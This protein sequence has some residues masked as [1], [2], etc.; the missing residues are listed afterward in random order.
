MQTKYIP[1]QKREQVFHPRVI[2]ITG[3]LNPYLHISRIKI[4][5]NFPD[6]Y[7]EV[8]CGTHRDRITSRQNTSTG[9]VSKWMKMKIK[10][11]PAV[12]LACLIVFFQ[13][14]QAQTHDTLF[15]ENFGTT[16]YWQGPASDYMGYSSSGGFS[17]NPILILNYLPSNY[18]GA[19]G[20]S[21]LILGVNPAEDTLMIS[22]IDT[23]YY[24]SLDLS[25]GV[26]AQVDPAADFRIAFSTDGINWTGFDNSKLLAGSWA[27]K[28]S[29]L[30]G[31]VTYTDSLPESSNLY[32]M[33]RNTNPGKYLYLDDIRINGVYDS[34]SVDFL[35]SLSADVGVMTPLFNS[36]ITQYNI[37]L[38][39]GTATAPVITAIAPTSQAVVKITG[40][41][42]VTSADES[43]RTATI[44]VQSGDGTSVREYTMV[45]RVD[46]KL[47]IYFEDFDVPGPDQ[48]VGPADKYS[49]RTSGLTTFLA[50]DSVK[51]DPFGSKFTSGS[52]YR[53]LYVSP[54]DHP[55][56][57]TITFANIDVT[58]SKEKELSFAFRWSTG[59]VDIDHYFPTVEV[60]VD[61]G[62]WINYGAKAGAAA[63]PGPQTWALVRIP[64]LPEGDTMSIRFSS[65][66]YSGSSQEYFIDDF[67]IL[68]KALCSDTTL[69]S[70]KID[71]CLLVPAFD[72]SVPVYHVDLEPGTTTVPVAEALEN[73]SCATVDIINASNPGAADSATRT[74]VIIIHAEDG[75]IGEYK[76]VFDYRP[77]RTEAHLAFLESDMGSLDPVFSP[78]SLDY[79]IDLPPGTSHTPGIKAISA[80]TVATL[81]ITS[82]TD[83]MSANE[84][85][86]TTTIQVLAEDTLTTITY[87]ILFNSRPLSS[88][89]HLTSLT[90]DAGILSPDFTSD[91]LGYL[92]ELLPGETVA[93]VIAAVPEDT[94]A[95]VF[96]QKAADILSSGDLDR[97]SIITVVAEDKVTT[98]TYMILFNVSTE[99]TAQIRQNNF[100]IWPNPSGDR[101]RIRGGGTFD[102]VEIS[103]LSG[104]LKMVNTVV[105]VGD[106]D[107][108]ISGL[109]NGI[110][111]IR[112]FNRGKVTGT[113]KLMKK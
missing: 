69:R 90:C 97:T 10:L 89:A 40:P 22:N 30:W 68:G 11:L 29:R 49:F 32:L 16:S 105:D 18:T 24:R 34:A 79:T 106:T 83:V 9:F 92:A 111:I 43:D 21:F 4:S 107:L 56:F 110:Y 37:M 28:N 5:F 35:K 31:Y 108:D 48:Y 59:W 23:R 45:F 103:D 112:L 47:P 61:G 55:G 58:K 76:I 13:D 17:V 85:D 71:S 94:N 41:V 72:P 3:F 36:R 96:I 81:S 26:N 93:P 100:T 7:F 70:L 77:L 86:R 20:Q 99:S 66:K 50:A 51:I 82:A 65:E 44:T 104:K 95:S 27:A 25:I 113:G 33:L 2:Q 46:D 102:R 63:F 74:T 75:T 1:V 52:G 14:L 67:A 38:P 88:E 64:G 8:P 12:I 78:D 53:R 15:N 84:E 19:S 87:H 57:D 80:D 62:N 60:K 73:D 39:Y 54:Y 6:V 42:D 98:L 91:V 109:E 101:I